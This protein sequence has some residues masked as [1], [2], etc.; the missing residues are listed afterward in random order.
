MGLLCRIDL[1]IFLRKRFKG[2]RKAPRA[3]STA[4]GRLPCS[5]PPQEIGS[6]L[7]S[8]LAGEGP[9]APSQWEGRVAL[10]LRA[11]G[12]PI[13]PRRDQLHGGTHSEYTDSRMS[14]DGMSKLSL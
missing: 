14:K 10:V 9:G 12:N 8:S 11:V 13:G 3:P 4:R 6:P 2:S 1:S 7:Y 5:E